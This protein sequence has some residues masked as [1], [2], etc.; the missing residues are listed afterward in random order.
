MKTRHSSRDFRWSK[1]TR[2]IR[3][4]LSFLCRAFAFVVLLQCVGCWW[5]PDLDTYGYQACD[6]HQDCP[7]SRLCS[8]QR[9]SPPGEAQSS[10][11]NNAA[12]YEALAYGNRQNDVQPKVVPVHFNTQAHAEISDVTLTLR[13]AEIVDPILDDEG[14]WIYSPRPLSV[15]H[16][17]DLTIVWLPTSE[18]LTKSDGSFVLPYIFL[19]ESLAEEFGLPELPF[20]DSIQNFRGD[21]A[22][23][24]SGLRLEPTSATPEFR[25]NELLLQADQSVY[26]STPIEADSTTSIAMSI[27]GRDC[28]RVYVGLVGDD[29]GG[30]V[31]PSTGLY[32]TD[33]F[34]AAFE[35]AAS[36]SASPIVLDAGRQ[37]QFGT[38]EHTY[39]FYRSQGS[40]SI[41]V[42]GVEW[43]TL[44]TESPRIDSVPLFLNVD[45]DG[46][47]S[48]NIR[49][50]WTS[51]GDS[52]HVSTQVFGPLRY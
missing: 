16:H 22:P 19:G 9:C 45:L 34:V 41:E 5:P 48:L 24:N 20:D 3:I 31:S 46:A 51:R 13:A 4:S 43:Y 18:T 17:E 28:D 38:V 29:R 49:E 2:P 1:R 50:M 37:H 35:V 12:R 14:R 32:F 36:A 7:G 30:Q 44:P 40:V 26:W 10:V 25:A 39:R 6:A 8:S 21:V 52:S 23:L 42:D 33:N 11:L 15:E 27:N 47:C